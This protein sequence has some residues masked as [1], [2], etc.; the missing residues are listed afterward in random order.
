M[1]EISFDMTLLDLAPFGLVSGGGSKPWH[2]SLLCLYLSQ[3]S[4]AARE[5]VPLISMLPTSMASLPQAGS[6]TLSLH[7]RNRSKALIN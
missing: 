6:S 3:V 4:V 7:S 2:C 1:V 5:K